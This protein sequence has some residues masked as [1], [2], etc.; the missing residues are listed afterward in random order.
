MLKGQLFCNVMPCSFKKQN[1][2]FHGGREGSLSSKKI[3][4]WT[5]ECMHACLE[6]LLRRQSGDSN[7]LKK[8][9]NERKV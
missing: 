4:D 6:L 1:S 8:K 9:K 7:Y 5:G 3:I 2:V